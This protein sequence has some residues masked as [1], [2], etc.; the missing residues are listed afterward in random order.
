M[1]REASKRLEIR[2]QDIVDSCN[3]LLNDIMPLLK[4]FSVED[5]KGTND[6]SEAYSI[7]RAKYLA[8]LINTKHLIT[9][10]R[11]SYF[12]T[13]ARKDIVE[14]KELADVLPNGTRV[15]VHS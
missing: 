12:I 5:Y 15:K 6:N 11:G 9:M 4:E 7:A 3:R 14:L 8:N 2:L 13:Y 10:L 1:E